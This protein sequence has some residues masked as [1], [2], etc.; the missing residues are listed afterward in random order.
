MTRDERT[1]LS[2]DRILAV[3]V[4]LAD[5]RGVDGLSMRKLAKQL[6][7]EVMSLYNHVDNK[8]DLLDGMVDAV[9]GEI[10]VPDDD[11]AWKTAVRQVAM[12]AHEALVRHRWAAAMWSRRWPGPNRWRH[13]DAL[14][15]LLSTADLPDDVADLGFHAVTM[16]IQG[17]TQQQIDYSNQVPDE[18]AMLERFRD[19]VSP[20]EFPHIVDHV[21][22]HRETEGLHDEFGFVLDLILDGL[23]R[24]AR[25]R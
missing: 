16:H 11:L 21:R 1:P 2:R 4:E 24:V 8:D 14:L 6:G 25:G 17:F 15:R 7:Y 3:A 9:A 13:M 20:D 10:V 5:E 23:E 19:D 18:D 22:Y 12:S